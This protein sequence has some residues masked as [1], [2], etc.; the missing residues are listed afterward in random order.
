MTAIKFVPIPLDVATRLL[1][2]LRPTNFA[3]TLVPRE[4]IEAAALTAIIGEAISIAGEHVP[5]VELLCA[6][7]LELIGRVSGR[8]ISTIPGPGSLTAAANALSET[9]PMLGDN[10]L[11]LPP[12]PERASAEAID[13][14]V[15]RGLAD[16]PGPIALRPFV[17]RKQ[18]PR[19]PSY[20]ELD[21]VDVWAV[22]HKGEP[23][24]GHVVLG[25]D[26]DSP[27]SVRLFLTAKPAGEGE[28]F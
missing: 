10:V 9:V 21:T 1:V 7:L 19:E 6:E 15:A 16:M 12:V 28:P 23:W 25:V 27:S 14:A 13:A 18:R 3:G 5:A 4:A 24:C 26:W 2:L 11:R 17:A 8:Q 22:P 20:D